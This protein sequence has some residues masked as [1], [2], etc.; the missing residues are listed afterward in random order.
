MAEPPYGIICNQL[1]RGEVIP[2]LGAGASLSGRPRDLEWDERSTG[3]LPTGRDLAKLLAGEAEFPS[4]DP[5][6]REDLAKVASY[7]LEQSDRPSL[8]ARLHEIFNR[9]YQVGEV[10]RFLANVPVPLLIVTTNYDDLI[11][12]AFRA[13]DKPYHL[14]VHP[15]ESK[16]LAGS[17]LWWKP[18]AAEPVS[19]PPAKLPLS[20]TDTTIIYKMHGSI[21]RQEPKWDSFVISE[22]DYVDFLSRMTGQ[23]AI[24]ARFMLHFRTRR[25]LFLGYGL[26]DWNLRV[27]L[28][29]LKSTL[30]RPEIVAS[31]DQPDVPVPEEGLRSWAVQY[32][33]SELEQ[34][35]WQARKVNIYDMMIDTFLARICERMG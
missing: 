19:Y 25:F 6:D 29:N 30:V 2:F 8:V 7:Y 27:V 24:P 10:H 14:V 35:L 17:V 4:S 11:E 3:F 13:V 33:P 20:V 16:E 28:K 15:T 5:H 32:K 23:T 31:S 22:E 18:G 1:K 26:A 12:Q 9:T 21:D 34:M